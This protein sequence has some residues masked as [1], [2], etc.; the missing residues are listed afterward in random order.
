VLTGLVH[1]L[2]TG[3]MAYASVTLALAVYDLALDAL[4]RCGCKRK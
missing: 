2:M 3:A 4:V 1:I